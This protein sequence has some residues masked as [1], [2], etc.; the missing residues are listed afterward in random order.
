MFFGLKSPWTSTRLV[1][2]V[3]STSAASRGARSGCASRRRDQVGLEPDRVEDGVGREARRDVG[4]V[5]G[6]G[7]DA[8]EH[9]ADGG[10]R[11]VSIAPSRSSVF[12]TG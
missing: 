10:A 8:A 7:V 12:H 4:P 1:V 9:V 2:R 5:G 3:V 6:R 11:R